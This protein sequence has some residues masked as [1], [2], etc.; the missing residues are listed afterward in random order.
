M[1]SMW[2]RLNCKLKW[3]GDDEQEREFSKVYCERSVYRWKNGSLTLKR[4]NVQDNNDITQQS[5]SSISSIKVRGHFGNV[6]VKPSGVFVLLT[7][8]LFLTAEKEFP[9]KFRLYKMA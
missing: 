9:H 7:F 2:E 8:L 3:N 5:L 4:S 1:L 6:F